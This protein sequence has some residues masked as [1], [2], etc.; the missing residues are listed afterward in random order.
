[1]SDPFDCQRFHELC[2]DYRGASPQA[3][4]AAYERLQEYCR[5]EI[6]R[7]ESNADGRVTLMQ[8]TLQIIADGLRPQR[9]EFIWPKLRAAMPSYID[10]DGCIRFGERPSAG[11]PGEG[12]GD[13]K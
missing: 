8:N 2:M 7:V 10:D 4:Q 6:Y 11:V 12:L 1:M 13:K 3:A 9:I 5:D